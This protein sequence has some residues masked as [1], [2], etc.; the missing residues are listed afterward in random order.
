MRNLIDIGSLVD[1]LFVNTLIKMNLIDKSLQNVETPLHSFT[2]N[3]VEPMG[4]IT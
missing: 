4:T 1:I 2:G 3:K